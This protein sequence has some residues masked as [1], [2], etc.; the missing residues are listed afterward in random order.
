MNVKKFLASM[1]VFAML[2]SVMSFTVFAEV[3]STLP[4][5]VD[6]VIT[7][8]EDVTL[9][10]TYK[11]EEGTT[12]TI[13]LDGHTIDVGFQT[14]SSEKHIYAIDNYGT[15]TLTGNGTINSRGI[16]NYGTLIIENGTYNSI[17]TN[18]GSAVWNYSGSKLTINGGTF[19]SADASTAP[20]ASTLYLDTGATAEINGGT[21]TANADWTYAIIS[22]G[23]ITIDDATVNSEHGAIAATNGSVIINGGSYNISG[24]GHVV[25][26]TEASVTIKDGSFSH[27]QENAT[28]EGNAIIYAGT[29]TVIVEGGNFYSVAAAFAYAS[30]DITL[31]GGSFTGASSKVYQSE[32]GDNVGSFAE[33]GTVITI[34]GTNFTKNEDGSIVEAKKVVATVN[35]EE[36]TDLQAAL[37]AVDANAEIVLCSDVADV[38]ATISKNITLNLGGKTVT[39]AYIII[40]GDVTIKNGFIK[41]TNEPYPLVVQ[42]GGKLTVENVAIEASKS[43]RAIWVRSGSELVFNSGSILATKGENNNKTNLIAA[44]YTDSNT[45]VTINGGT[46]TVDTPNNKA[47]GIFGNYTNA[48][49]TVNDGKISTSGKNYSYGINVDGDITVNGGEIVTNEKGYGYSSGIRYGNNYALVTA[50]GDVTITGGTITTNGY[51]GYIVNVGRNYQSNAQTVTITGGTLK[52]DLSEVEKTTGGHKAP[53][54]VWEGSASPVT[55]TITDGDFSGFSADLLRKDNEATTTL[56]VSGG[57]FDVNVNE[58]FLADGFKMKDNGDGTYGVV[59]QIWTTDY[60]ANGNTI[61]FLFDAN[62]DG[63][64]ISGIKFIKVLGTDANYE[65]AAGLGGETTTS[66]TFYGDVTDVPEGA[67]F[68]AV[69]FVKLGDTTYWSVPVMGKLAQ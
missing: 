15:L 35:G 11:I 37:D 27:T 22:N 6:G 54:L 44:I 7:L 59:D 10:E 9:S 40:T 1:L 50:T 3:A 45:D 26:V 69:A 61:R 33:V 24:S 57:T 21:F 56:T 51:S 25:Y 8:T 46:I 13:N 42:N 52:N 39:D 34:D 48:N 20:A 64:V 38:D 68:Y 5:A 41:N 55:A 62:I 2:L 14:G 29:N 12:L 65:E 63:E 4:V 36:F 32:N 47:I 30:A 23:D 60:A 28:S 66:K 31:K 18:G 67:T 49:V 16:G 58:E 43:D 53:V 17:D 19:T